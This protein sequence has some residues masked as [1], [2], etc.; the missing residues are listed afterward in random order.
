MGG[1]SRA[2]YPWKP[3]TPR[4]QTAL[5]ETPGGGGQMP[6]IDP[7]RLACLRALGQKILWLAT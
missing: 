2:R 6:V 5:R 1:A 7:D 4:G 3:V